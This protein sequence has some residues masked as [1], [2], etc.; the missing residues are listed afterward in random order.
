MLQNATSSDASPVRRV[1][2]PSKARSPYSLLVPSQ[3]ST[4]SILT[5]VQ[6]AYYSVK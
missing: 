1:L 6:N 5:R 2:A 4:I 3:Q